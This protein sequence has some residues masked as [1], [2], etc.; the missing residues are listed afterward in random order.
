LRRDRLFS[1][2]EINHLVV[3]ATMVNPKVGRTG[4]IIWLQIT[5]EQLVDAIAKLG[6]HMEQLTVE[7]WR[8]SVQSDSSSSLWHAV[9]DRL[10]LD[11]SEAMRLS[12]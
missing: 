3:Y 11:R 5:L 4:K 7:S 10:S 8:L 12:L 1:L 6:D 2:V 9:I